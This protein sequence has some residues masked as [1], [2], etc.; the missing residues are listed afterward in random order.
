MMLNHIILPKQSATV[1]PIFNELSRFT[2]NGEA[3]RFFVCMS[4]C[5]PCRGQRPNNINYFFSKSLILP[6]AYVE[7]LFIFYRTKTLLSSDGIPS[8][9][10]PHETRLLR[11]SISASFSFLRVCNCALYASATLDAA[12]MCLR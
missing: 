3:I 7:I 9:V 10:S 6:Y 4:V 12:L 5:L 11:S 8:T 1:P 2:L